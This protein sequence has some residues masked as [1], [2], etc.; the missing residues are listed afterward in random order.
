M[1]IVQ[2]SGRG[3]NDYSGSGRPET[4]NFA[5]RECKLTK[6][7]KDSLGGKSLALMIACASLSSRAKRETLR[8]L[9]FAMGVKNIRN[10]P[11]VLLDPHEKLVQQ[12]KSE[13]RRLR[14]E[15]SRLRKDATAAEM[16]TGPGVSVSS[17]KARQE[18]IPSPISLPG[19]DRP[20]HRAGLDSTTSAPGTTS[21]PH[22]KPLYNSFEALRSGRA[23]ISGSD[24]GDDTLSSDFL[25]QEKKEAATVPTPVERASVFP[26]SPRPA[27]YLR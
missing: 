12:L 11:V 3:L 20:V 18:R 15:N 16:G 5:F 9:K 8:T 21:K 26:P 17:L 13:I 1:R 6:L 27:L 23:G 7:L 2:G 24:D 25:F 19:V 22:P 4:N 10:T 14:H